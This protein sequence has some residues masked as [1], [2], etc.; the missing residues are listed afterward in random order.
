MIMNREKLYEEIWEISVKKVAEKYN[1]NYSK[2]LKVCK[3]NDIPIPDSKYWVTLRTGQD[4]SQLIV[5]LPESDYKE[6]VLPLNQNIRD[7]TSEE[8]DTKPE[9][10]LISNIGTRLI[11]E[12]LY[13]LSADKIE[14][15]IN[16]MSEYEIR[17]NKRLHKKVSSFKKKVDLWE[18]KEKN[19]QRD[20]LDP[21]YERNDMEQPKFIKD[22]SKDN[23]NRLFR[24]LD[25][26]VEIFEN[27]GETITDDFCILIE[28]DNVCFDIIESTTKVKHEITKEE[29]K[30]LLEYED[31]QKHGGYVFKPNI[32]KYD[33]PF[34]GKFRI[35]FSSG[36]YLKD[37]KDKPLE[38][39]LE[40]LIIMFYEAYY[41][42]KTKREEREKERRQWE[43]EQRKKEEHR[44]RIKAEKEKTMQLLNMLTDYRL[45]EDIRKF[46]EV[47]S[48]NKNIDNKRLKWMLEKADWIDPI[49]S[50]EDE[51]LGKRQH[52]E[53]AE[54]KLR[55]LKNNN[56]TFWGGW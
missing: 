15:I 50:R 2:L 20:Y 46:A 47:L 22:V 12:R 53:D 45:A 42:I 32:R 26:I 27:I 39:M 1:L 6:I 17:E 40:E 29:A 25:I 19:S 24:L 36:K 8:I 37:K 56:S 30:Q 48:T 43:E 51:L 16:V 54:L 44:D 9:S 21:R 31:S 41:D 7:S 49:V 33:Y 13:F 5:P 23:R 18:K 3:E 11:R 10:K 35:K 34:N 38:E 4:V 55:F 28:E 52:H 14:K